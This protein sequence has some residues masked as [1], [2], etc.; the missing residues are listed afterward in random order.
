M[1]EK[2]Y[3][4]A[5]TVLKRNVEA[6]PVYP[7]NYAWLA[8]AYE[9]NKDYAKALQTYQQALERSVNINYGQEENYTSHIDRLKRLLEKMP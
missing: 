8:D 9:Q 1:K 3:D 6:Y 7:P 5:I 2:N 4:G